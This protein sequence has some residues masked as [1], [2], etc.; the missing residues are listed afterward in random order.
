MR[1]SIGAS[2]AAAALWLCGCGEPYDVERSTAAVVDDGADHVADP[3][4]RAVDEDR[5]GP[6]DPGYDAYGNPC[7]LDDA[8]GG[9]PDDGAHAP[10][11]DARDRREEEPG[12]RG[13]LD[14]PRGADQR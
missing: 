13:D 10:A 5:A 3:T 8:A 4:C 11:E 7:V 9:A 12:H 6:G 1:R 2:C 14:R